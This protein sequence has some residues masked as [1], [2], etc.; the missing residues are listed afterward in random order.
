MNAYNE[1]KESIKIHMDVVRWNQP[2]CPQCGMK[3]LDATVIGKG[4]MPWNKRFKVSCGN[5]DARGYVVADTPGDAIRSFGMKQI[6]KKRR[7]RNEGISG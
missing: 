4:T 2:Y 7:K 1:L 6:P 3:S 5:C